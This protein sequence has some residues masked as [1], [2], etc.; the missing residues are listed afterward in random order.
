MTR[1][2]SET[3]GVAEGFRGVG[4]KRIG[5]QRGGGVLEG[6]GSG[7]GGSAGRWSEFG[8]VENFFRRIES[9]GFGGFIFC[10]TFAAVFNSNY[11]YKM[12]K[13]I[14]EPF[15]TSLQHLR[16]GSHYAFFAD[17]VIAPLQS[18]VPLLPELSSSFGRLGVKVAS[19]EILYKTSLASL[20]TP[21]L[22]LLSR[23]RNAGFDLFKKVVNYG[24]FAKT[25]AR[26]EAYKKLLPLVGVYKD[27]TKG[28]YTDISG[29]LTNFIIDCEKPEYQTPLQALALMDLYDDIKVAN[30]LFRSKYH[31]REV[32]KEYLATRGKLS[33]IRPEVDGAFVEFVDVLNSAWI[34]NEEALKDATKR[35][36]LRKIEVALKAAIHQMKENLERRGVTAGNKDNPDPIAPEAP[37]DPSDPHDPDDSNPPSV[38]EH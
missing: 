7:D 10:I 35:D 38:G 22:K 26:K 36:N 8:G 4:G 28:T 2:W 37:T 16:I 6:S 3:E 34:Y 11:T 32:D 31:D 18:L 12:E 1:R 24:E 9:D 14:T 21:E 29:K 27:A 13:P 5:R 30:N 23:E 15:K 20:L 19:E 33:Q 25:D 17:D